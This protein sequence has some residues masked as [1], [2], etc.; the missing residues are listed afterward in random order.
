MRI[1]RWEMV[2]IGHWSIPICHFQS[3]LTAATVY[4]A[5]ASFA[6][7]LDEVASPPMSR[8]SLDS[9]HDVVEGLLC[10]QFALDHLNGSKETPIAEVN[11]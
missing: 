4:D 6:L 5:N 9:A 1:D 7:L 11:Q 8:V 2:V 10:L 3:F